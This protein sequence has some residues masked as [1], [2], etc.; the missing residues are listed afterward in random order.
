VGRDLARSL[1]LT[2]IAVGIGTWL[3]PRGSLAVTKLDPTAP[4]SPYL[5]RLFAAREAA[6][7]VI[8]LVAVGQRESLLTLGLVVDGLDTLAGLSA[9]RS[10]SAGPAT[11]VLTGVAA[12][13]V[14]IGALALARARRRT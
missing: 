8:T 4:Q 11:G 13:G 9:S 12:G 14:A 5:L 2:R 3:A 10:P 6:L 7:G 1:A